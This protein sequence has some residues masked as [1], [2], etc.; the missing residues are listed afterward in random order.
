MKNLTVIGVGRLG[1]CF[2]LTLEKAGYNVIGCDVLP[3]YV[4]SLNDKTFNSFEP[5]VNELLQR[6]VNF[7]A[8]NDLQKA[9]AHS[10]ILFVTVASYSEP[11]GQYDVSQVDSVVTQL[12]EL[13]KQEHKK[14]LVICTNVNPGYSDTVYGQLK[15]Y[16]WEVSFN[17]ETIAQGTILKDQAEPDCESMF[18]LPGMHP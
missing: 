16:N 13:G 14:H 7:E 8:I 2:C 11:D 5:G 15:D 3:E 12:K 6:S 18:F 1:L 4:A 9:V 10:D 17:P